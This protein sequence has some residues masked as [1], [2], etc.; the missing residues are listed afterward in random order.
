[1]PRRQDQVPKQRRLELVKE[2]LR[3][4]GRAKPET[5]MARLA[6]RMSCDVGEIRRL[7]YSDLKELSERVEVFE[8]RYTPS[9][10]LLEDYDPEVH[11][12]TVV[13]YALQESNEVIL[14]GGLLQ[15]RGGLMIPSP[16]M[17]RY[18]KLKITKEVKLGESRDKNAAQRWPAI[19]FELGEDILTLSLDPDAIPASLTIGRTPSDSVIFSSSDLGKVK[20]ILG[21]RESYVF[22]PVKSVSRFKGEE[23]RGHFSIEFKDTDS[24][25]VTDLGSSHKTFIASVGRD[26]VDGVAISS[27][28]GDG[29]Q[30]PDESP[31]C[32]KGLPQS[33]SEWRDIGTDGQSVKLPFYLK[34]GKFITLVHVSVA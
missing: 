6:E 22:L 20:S 28:V 27:A 26:A 19:S 9:G 2:V 21:K 7:V 11:R 17:C 25:V 10:E 32:F 8:F 15:E 4:E 24:A 34:A 14:G 12:N 5:V 1:M 18:W 29:T 30:Q 3:H 33:E 16:R 31:V 23:R 13:E